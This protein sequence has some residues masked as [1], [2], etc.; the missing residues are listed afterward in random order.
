MR[1]RYRAAAAAAT[2][3]GSPDVTRV[4]AP[5]LHG[6]ETVMVLPFDSGLIPPRLNLFPPQF[7]EEAEEVLH[8]QGDFSPPRCARLAADTIAAMS[9][10]QA[11]RLY[12]RL[13]G[14]SP[15]SV[16]DPILS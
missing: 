3:N 1:F 14:L 12:Q 5:A 13:T 4:P 7:Q 15:G 2:E 10:E 8:K 9:D 11:L 6:Q 16:L